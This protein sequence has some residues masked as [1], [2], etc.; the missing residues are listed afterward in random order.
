MIVLSSFF[1]RNLHV[2]LRRYNGHIEIA[3]ALLH[4]HYFGNEEPAP[5]PSTYIYIYIKDSYRFGQYRTP[6]L[7][8][9]QKFHF[10]Y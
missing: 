2:H 8:G 3:A 10:Y 6:L 7:L 9:V 1:G 4:S 5:V